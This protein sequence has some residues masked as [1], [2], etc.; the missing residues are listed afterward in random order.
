M[1]KSQ[2]DHG[3]ITW[4]ASH[5]NSKTEPVTNAQQSVN[6]PQP[7]NTQLYGNTPQPTSME[8]TAINFPFSFFLVNNSIFDNRIKSF[9]L[10]EVEA[11]TTIEYIEKHKPSDTVHPEYLAHLSRPT[12]ERVEFCD[13]TLAALDRA[14]KQ[15]QAPEIGILEDCYE[16]NKKLWEKLRGLI[17]AHT[18]SRDSGSESQSSMK[19]RWEHRQRRT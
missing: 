4:L 19:Q 7:A 3:M 6:I 5:Q 18:R 1:S 2:P 11:I 14:W 15:S 17:D 12:K 8:Q 9:V 13:K 10:D 16:N